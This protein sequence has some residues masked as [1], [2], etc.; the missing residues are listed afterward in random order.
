MSKKAKNN[1]S[2]V[3]VRI[4]DCRE[5]SGKIMLALFGEDG[6]GGIVKDVQEIKS[7]TSIIKTVI[8]PVVISVSA[9]L[10][11]YAVLNAI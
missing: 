8:V 6:R 2:R 7:A 1:P 3:Y 4:E 10:I 5:I 9:A 11:T